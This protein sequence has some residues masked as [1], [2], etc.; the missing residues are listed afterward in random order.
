MVDR[1]KCV[2]AA[3]EEVSKATA[4]SVTSLEQTSKVL[5]KQELLLG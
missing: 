3:M 5:L 2:F 4:A 1:R